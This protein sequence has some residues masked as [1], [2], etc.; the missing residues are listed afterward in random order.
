MKALPYFRWYPADAETDEFYSS[1]NDAE[2][3]FFHRCLNKS[4]INCGLPADSAQLGKIL[5]KPKG[6]VERMWAVVGHAFILTET[7]HPRSVNPRQEEERAYAT[8][9]SA[10]SSEAASARERLKKS[11]SSTDVST[12]HPRAYDCGSDSVEDKKKTPVVHEY[13]KLAAEVQRRF[14]TADSVLV[15]RIAMAAAQAYV[16]V[17]NPR[18]RELDDA[19]MAEAVDK[20]SRETPKQTSAGL[21][22]STVPAVITSWAKHGRNGAIEPSKYVKYNPEV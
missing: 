4:W 22:V 11:R 2:L 16:A 19:L 5:G 14:P 7:A 12:D 13:P 8:K 17:D 10:Q 1:L 15:Q 6:Y 18:I 3:G 20:A 21:Y 9:K